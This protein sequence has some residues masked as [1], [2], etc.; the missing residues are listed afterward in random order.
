MIENYQDHAANERTFL[1][2]VRTAVAVVGIGLIVVNTQ[3]TDGLGAPQPHTGMWLLLLGAVLI[4]AA[5]LRFLLLRILIRSKKVTSSIP[6][7]LD[8]S[9]GIILILMI[10]T[11][12]G[13]GSYIT[14][15]FK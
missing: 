4:F 13:F 10:A 11:L 6:V 14:A 7:M 1:S 3:N 9:L 8:V 15:I 5:G 2:W 12:A